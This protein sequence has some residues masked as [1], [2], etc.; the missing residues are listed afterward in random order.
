MQQ[1]GERADLASG[2]AGLAQILGKP[3]EARAA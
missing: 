2:Y 3:A 1:K